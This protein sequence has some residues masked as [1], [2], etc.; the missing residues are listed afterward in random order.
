MELR[1]LWL[2]IGGVSELSSEDIAD[3]SCCMSYSLCSGS[4]LI[5]NCLC[6]Q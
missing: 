1:L 4:W 6:L 5:A 2:A 3:A